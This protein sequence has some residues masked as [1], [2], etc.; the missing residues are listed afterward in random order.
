MFSSLFLDFTFNSND[1]FWTNSITVFSLR[2]YSYLKV[3]HFAFGDILEQ[4]EMT[5]FA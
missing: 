4:N 3:E 2:I 1:L 5:D